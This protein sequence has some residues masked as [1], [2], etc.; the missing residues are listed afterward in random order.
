MGWHTD[1][2]RQDRRLILQRFGS[3]RR[4]GRVQ[5]VPQIVYYIWFPSPLCDVSKPI[6]RSWRQNAPR[7]CFC[8][9]VV[10][11]KYLPADRLSWL[12]VFVVFLR[13]SRSVSPDTSNQP[14]NAPFYDI[15]THYSPYTLCCES[16]NPNLTHPQHR[17]IDN[18]HNKHTFLPSKLRT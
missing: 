14:Q 15:T 7:C 13:L 5:S 18:K 2:R 17:Y 12:T 11:F 8:S 16:T 10:Q 9:T 4:N 6:H 3:V 1:V